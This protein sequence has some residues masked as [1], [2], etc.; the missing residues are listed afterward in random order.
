MYMNKRNLNY[1]KWTELVSLN[2]MILALTTFKNYFMY[3]THLKQIKHC[4]RYKNINEYFKIYKLAADT[5]QS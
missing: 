2:A 4:Y 3:I 5:K 1:Y